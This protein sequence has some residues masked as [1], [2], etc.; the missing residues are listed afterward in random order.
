MGDQRVL[1]EG[2]GLDAGNLCEAV[3]DALVERDVLR[4]GVAGGRGLNGEEQE[5]VG[6]EAEAGGVEVD[7]GA[8]KE[9]GADDEQ[10]GERDLEDDDGFAG[11]AFTA[12]GGRRGGILEGGVDVGAG[13]LPC[14]C[15]AE[16]D[17]GEDGDRSSEGED[18]E[19]ETGGEGRGPPGRGE[20]VRE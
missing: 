6:V 5:I 14:G 15:E 12:A 10:H 20:Q 19:V 4:R 2:D 9:T 17:A 3:F 1:D 13:G 16:D 8:S 18:A 11:E 7:Q